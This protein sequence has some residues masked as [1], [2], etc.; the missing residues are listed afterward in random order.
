MVG[1][2]K[3]HSSYANYYFQVG[4]IDIQKIWQT[5]PKNVEK[6]FV[7]QPIQDYFCL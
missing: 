7:H 1:N 3:T 6:N 4:S 2:K 5:H